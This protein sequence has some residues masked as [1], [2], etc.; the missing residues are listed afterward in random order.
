MEKYKYEFSVIAPVYN[1]KLFL[2]EAADSVINQDCGLEKIQL[3]LVDD[4]STDGSGEICDEYAEKYPSNIIVIHKENGGVSS[5]RNTGLDRAQGRYVGFLDTDDKYGANTFREVSRFFSEHAEETDVVSIPVQ[6]FDAFTGKHTL[7]YKFERGTRVIDL[8]KECNMIQLHPFVFIKAEAIGKERFDEQLAYSEDA[9]FVNRILLRKRTLGVAAEAGYYYRKRK[10]GELSALQKSSGNKQFYSPCI[11]R[12]HDALFE[13]AASKEVPVPKFIQYVSAYELQWRLKTSKIK[14]GVLTEEEKKEY[15]SR[16]YRAVS[17]LDDDVIMGQIVLSDELKMYALK[18]K[19]GRDPDISEADGDILCSY[20][21][22]AEFHLSDTKPVLEFYEL[23]KDTC[24]LEGYVVK[25]QAF[26]NISVL[27]EINGKKTETLPVERGEILQ[28]QDETAAGYQGFKITFPVSKK[29]RKYNIR[30]FVVVKN[31]RVEIKSL[32][33]R[34]F[35]PV[36]AKYSSAYYRKD[37]WELT[38][39][40][41]ALA[42]VRCTPVSAIWKELRFCCELWKKNVTGSRKAVAA[43][44][45]YHLL[46]PFKRKQLWM[47]SDRTMKAGDNGE[48]LFRYLQAHPRKDRKVFF[49]LNTD[50]P[51]YN[52]LS[53]IGP[54]VGAYSFKRKLLHLLCDLNISSHADRIQFYPFLGYHDAYRDL[55]QHIRFIYLQHGIMQANLS[56]WLGRSSRNI[57]GIVTSTEHENKLILEGGYR[58][59][60]KNIWLA[61]STRFDLWYHDEK[62]IVTIMPTWRQYLS[63]RLK[64]NGMR[65]VADDFVNSQ[66]FRFYNAL[67]NDKRLLEAADKYHY[68]I[69]FMPHPNVQPALSSFQRNKQVKFLGTDANCGQV[70]AESDLLITDYS[71]VG[72]DFAYLRK[73]VIYSQFDAD[74]FL[75]GNHIYSEGSLNF[76]YERD[77][78]GEVEHDLEST[79]DRIIEYMENDCRLKE[80]YRKRIDS[81][82][83]FDDRKNCE[84]VLK[85]LEEISEQKI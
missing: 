51:D 1:V 53:K 66:Y 32:I 79:V 74:S 61:G 38:Q 19:Y 50:S 54:V 68:K 67:V 63:G 2:R 20:S 78:F 15:L 80:K 31:V 46:R 73:P 16:F 28:T 5:A 83:A 82:F 43:R 14:P 25:W 44:T 62:R 59:T 6:F 41:G 84:R 36:S 22:D 76:E 45:A 56:G 69:Q 52:E 30:F 71:S 33:F 64:E 60:E 55:L 81:F 65:D 12:F 4:G 29:N 17:R 57:T 75:A 70:Y 9:L 35:F 58:Y 27:A 85:K 34:E 3:I 21:K 40:D 49:I 24:S 13:Y 11:E 77:G 23:E 10:E 72:F 7:N 39:K 26:D 8:R 42:I 18:I 37:G 47:L 48:A